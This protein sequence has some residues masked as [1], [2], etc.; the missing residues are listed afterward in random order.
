MPTTIDEVVD[1]IQKAEGSELATNCSQLK[2]QPA[3]ATEKK[4]L[5]VKN[6]EE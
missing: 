3:N 1:T 4:S 6:D 2:L 5:D